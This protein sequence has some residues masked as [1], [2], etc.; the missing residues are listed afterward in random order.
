VK[1]RTGTL[2]NACA[3]VLNEV[4]TIQKIGKRKSKSASTPTT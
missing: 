3:V 2:V 1:T 4:S